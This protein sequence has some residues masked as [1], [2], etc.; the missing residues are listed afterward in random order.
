MTVQTADGTLIDDETDTDHYRI[1]IFIIVRPNGSHG[2]SNLSYCHLLLF[3]DCDV[4][5]VCPSLKNK[6]CFKKKKEKASSII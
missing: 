2:S 6:N 3:M 1:G 5:K 4:N